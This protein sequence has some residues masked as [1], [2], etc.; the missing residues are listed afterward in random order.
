MV[1]KNKFFCG[2]KQRPGSQAFQLKTKAKTMFPLNRTI[3]NSKASEINIKYEPDAP[4][5]VLFSS[6][7]SNATGA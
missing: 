5:E 6:L 1:I 3:F 7:S 4:Q 2:F